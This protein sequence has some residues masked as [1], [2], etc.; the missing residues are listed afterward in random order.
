MAAAVV[1]NLLARQSRP[2]KTDVGSEVYGPWSRLPR[3]R[4]EA[5]EP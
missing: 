2:G 4:P 1:L 5:K 3:A